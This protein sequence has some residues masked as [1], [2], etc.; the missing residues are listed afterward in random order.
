MDISTLII[1]SL[2]SIVVGAATAWIMAS[3]KLN[4]IKDILED[5]LQE[6]EKEN[7][8][9]NTKSHSDATELGRSNSLNQE[10]KNEKQ[11]L[12]QQLSDSRAS[13]ASSS[14][15]AKQLKLQ[16]EE[17]KSSEATLQVR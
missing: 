7:L 1:T 10:L 3:I 16:L 5:Q 14:E 6:L 9:V 11:Q 15:E 2:L 17:S 13:L 8:V 12:N 4:K